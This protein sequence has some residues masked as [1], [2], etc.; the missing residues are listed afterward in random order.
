MNDSNVSTWKNLCDRDRHYAETVAQIWEFDLA[1]NIHDPVRQIWP[2][3]RE[4]QD[5]GRLV[6]GKEWVRE[7]YQSIQP[8]GEIRSTTHY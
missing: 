5:R 8:P 1:F 3:H 2:H 7:G 4:A 6:S